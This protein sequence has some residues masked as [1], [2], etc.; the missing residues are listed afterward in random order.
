MTPNIANE[1][2]S[3]TTAMAVVLLVASFA[4]LGVINLLERRTQAANSSAH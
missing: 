1:A 4:M 2:T 3:S